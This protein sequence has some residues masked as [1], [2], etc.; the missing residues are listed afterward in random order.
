MRFKMI[1]IGTQGDFGGETEE[2]KCIITA[3][4]KVGVEPN[5]IIQ[6]IFVGKFHSVLP[7]NS[8][9]CNTISMVAK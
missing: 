4:C 9:A 2:T 5:G 1:R 7:G 6:V 8:S 3:Y